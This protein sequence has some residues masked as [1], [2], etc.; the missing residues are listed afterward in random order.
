MQTIKFF[1]SAGE[2]LIVLCCCFSVTPKVV[3][4]LGRWTHC[5]TTPDSRPLGA[6][7]CHI[8][9]ACVFQY[10]SHEIAVHVLSSCCQ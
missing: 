6:Y 1:V 10:M 3:I 7:T 4:S 8:L 2:K 9:H 5:G